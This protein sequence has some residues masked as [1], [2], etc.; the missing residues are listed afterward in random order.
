MNTILQ[1][2]IEEAAK[3][4]AVKNAPLIGT[5]LY[6]ECCYNSALEAANFALQNQWISVEEALPEEDIPNCFVAY[7]AMDIVL[8]S[9][10]SYEKDN[11][12]WY[13]DGIGFNAE[14]T[15]YMPIPELK[16][17]EK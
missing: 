17:G 14:V 10:G 1:Q 4:I 7:K 8:Y 16:G 2:R 6:D 12:E 3:F 11:D 15:H 9:T 5:R 13:V